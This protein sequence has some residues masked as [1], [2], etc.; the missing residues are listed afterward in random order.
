MPIKPIKTKTIHGYSLLKCKK[1]ITLFSHHMP[2][3]EIDEL[4]EF[5][6]IL[7]EQ[8]L[9]VIKAEIN[10]FD[11]SLKHQKKIVKAEDE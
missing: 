4:Q 2:F 1:I 11:Y 3:F 9:R 5:D 6:M 7:G 8:G 10:L